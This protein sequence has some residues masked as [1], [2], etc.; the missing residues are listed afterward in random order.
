MSIA[1]NILPRVVDANTHVPW[2]HLHGPTNA[3]EWMYVISLIVTM[4]TLLTLIIFPRQSWANFWLASLIVPLLLSILYTFVL[5]IGFFQEVEFPPGTVIARYSNPLEFFSLP[6]LRLLFAKDLLLLAGFLDLL[7]M[8]LLVASWMT[9]KAAQV[10]MPYVYLVI[11]VLL[12]FGAPGTGFVFF[13]L[14]VGLSRGGWA[15]IAR[16]DSQPP[17]NTAPVYAQPGD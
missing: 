13:A 16:F 2:W 8:P 10:R 15:Q 3:A 5:F 4:V 6:G 1:M 9:R 14:F 12:T 11:C 7:I 17:F